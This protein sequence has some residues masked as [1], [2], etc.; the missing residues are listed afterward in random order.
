[1]YFLVLKTPF[2]SSFNNFVHSRPSVFHETPPPLYLY[3]ARFT[4]KSWEIT[5]IKQL[6]ACE[7]LELKQKE[8][9]SQFELYFFSNEILPKDTSKLPSSWE[10]GSAFPEWRATS[11]LLLNGTHSTTSYQG[12]TPSFDAVKSS[13]FCNI[14]PKTVKSD[15]HLLFISVHTTSRIHGLLILLNTKGD[16]V[17]SHPIMTNFY[18]C[19]HIPSD[20]LA[21]VELF[22]IKGVGGIPFF[23]LS[24][25]N[26][27]SI[28]HTHPPHSAV[29]STQRQSFN[30][31][32]KRSI[33]ENL[34]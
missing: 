25:D 33:F 24:A 2:T 12:E 29:I 32:L 18:N 28:E 7:N 20:I 9:Y 31:Q 30:S 10:S 23:M 11:G 8:T 16:Q 17:A 13:I 21:Q 26:T 19:I 14:I 27:L 1:M 4:S 34:Q 6:E 3:N 5:R 15:V 22:V